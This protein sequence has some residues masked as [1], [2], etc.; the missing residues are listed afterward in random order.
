MKNKNTRRGFTHQTSY[1]G[2]KALFTSPLEGEDVRRTDEGETNPN[3]LL[4]CRGGNSTVTPHPAFGH[5][6]PQGA[7]KATYGFTARAVTP[8]LR[9]A[10]YA[11]YSGR[12]GFTP[13]PRHPELDSGSRRFMKKEEALNK[14][15]FRAPLR[16]GFTLIELLVVVLIIGILAAVAVPQYQLAVG[17]AQFSTL[18]ATTRSLGEFAHVYYLEHGTYV[19]ATAEAREILP[20]GISCYIWD[21]TQ[22]SYIACTKQISN[23]E[24]DFYVTRSSRKPALCLVRSTKTTDLPNKLCQ[25]ETGKKGTCHN[26]YCIYS[27]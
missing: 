17:R 26:N 8:T 4:L 7:R 21:E 13:T 25:K 23:T 19:G 16:S 12:P 9:A 27:Y 2:Q 22:Q 1:T 11:G 18:K 3:E 5:P 20:K 14:S 10:I 24:T 15:S 6:L